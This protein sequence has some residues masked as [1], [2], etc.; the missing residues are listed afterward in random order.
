MSTFLRY[1]PTVSCLEQRPLCW[2][3][4]RWQAGATTLHKG[5][6][7]TMTHDTIR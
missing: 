3:P 1:H 6:C 2:P 4:Q 7:L 5:S